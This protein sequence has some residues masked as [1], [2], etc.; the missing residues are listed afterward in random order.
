MN[1]TFR[2]AFRALFAGSESRWIVEKR[3]M[4]L[5]R[6]HLS[7]AQ[8]ARFDAVGNFEVT[9]NESGCRYLVRNTGSINV[10]Q[11]GKNGQCVQKWCFGPEG[12]LARGDMLLAQKLA[13][14]CFEGEALGRAYRYPPHSQR[15]AEGNI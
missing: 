13:L 9:G 12:N 2:Q 6:S 8:R 15:Q 3:A 7:P 5:L 14:E 10:E 11:L 1:M 4:E